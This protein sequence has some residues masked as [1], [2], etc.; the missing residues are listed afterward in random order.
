[1]RRIAIALAAALALTGC[2]IAQFEQDASAVIAKVKSQAPVVIAEIDAAVNFVCT[3][4]LPTA[5]ATLTGI[6][7][8]FPN[9]GPRTA[10]ALRDGNVAIM[11]A[12][13][14]CDAYSGTMSASGKTN[15]LL[16][17]WNAYN[18]GRAAAVTANAAAGT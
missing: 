15:L 7:T 13:A 16:K 6:M 8:A 18:A 17:M 4:G 9:P 1:M 2:T 14:A 5:N 3:N 10:K 11:S 12:V